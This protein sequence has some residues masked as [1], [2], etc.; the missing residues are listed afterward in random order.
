MSAATIGQGA[1]LLTANADAMLSGLDRARD[2]VEDWASVTSRVAHK[3]ERAI[4]GVTDAENRA[5]HAA[6]GMK[7]KYDPTVNYT[8]GVTGGKGGGIGGPFGK[9][10][11]GLAVG[12]ALVAGTGGAGAALAAVGLG[13]SAVS[14]GL[15]LASHAAEK[16]FDKLSDVG[17]LAKKYGNLSPELEAGSERAQNAIDRMSAAGDEFV[18][19]VAEKL[20]PYLEKAASVLEVV[21]FVGAE[22]FGE[23][24]D[25]VGEVVTSIAQWVDET[26]GLATATTSAGDQ[27]FAVLR[28]IGEGVAYVWDGV[29]AGAGI[30]SVVAGSIVQGFGKVVEVI[31]LAAKE[32]NKLAQD[33]PEAIRPDWA[34][35]NIAWLDGFAGK[36]NDIGAGM[37]KWGKDA[38][39]GFGGGVD[40]INWWF[41]QIQGKFTATDRLMKAG[42]GADLAKLSG[43]FDMNSTEAYSIVTK[44]AAGNQIADAQKRQ[45]ALALQQVGLLGAIKDHLGRLGLG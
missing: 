3:A 28:A 26:F 37:E 9:L 35:K 17:E 39:M 21:G 13:I 14:A 27:T 18:I 12:G 30:V 34:T 44:N 41:D 4:D 32:L 5:A 36:V 22:V 43:A 38:I 29:K 31:V 6:S 11:G 1:V 10:A 33:L 20:A 8:K 25:A 23:I 42:A 2:G 19:R 40:Q 45:A 24:L 15:D 7:G 16:F